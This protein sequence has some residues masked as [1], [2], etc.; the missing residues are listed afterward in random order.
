[1]LEK[2][3]EFPKVLIDNKDLNTSLFNIITFL[4]DRMDQ[5]EL[6]IHNMLEE[7]D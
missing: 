3:Q 4:K 6:V 7:K 5:Y 2:S 1:M